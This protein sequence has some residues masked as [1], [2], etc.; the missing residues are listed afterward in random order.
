[1]VTFTEFYLDESNGKHGSR[2]LI[3][4]MVLLAS[5]LLVLI[6]AFFVWKKRKNGQLTR[7]EGK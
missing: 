3:I 6:L 1:M 2:L 7:P 5:V 4:L